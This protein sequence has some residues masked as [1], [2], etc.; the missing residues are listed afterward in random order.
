MGKTINIIE[1]GL[2]KGDILLLQAGD[3][4]PADLKLIEAR[5]FEVDE[6]DLTGEIMPVEKKVIEEDV[7]VY[8]GSRVI[9][10]NAKG[11]VIATGEETE[12]G[13]ILKQRWGQVKYKVPLLIKRK[14][15]ILLVFLLPSLIF[16]LSPFSDSALVYVT[17]LAMAVFVILIQNND[18]FKYIITSNEIEKIK[19]YNAE[20][21]DT[22]HEEA[23]INCT[24]I[25]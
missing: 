20:I 7:F 8:K 23:S 11:V 22:T 18:L 4:V 10:G 19:S 24:T 3:L 6:F 21:L 12:Y 1:D 5:N 2:S 25:P 9:R 16:T 13:E 15:L 14:Y 17:G